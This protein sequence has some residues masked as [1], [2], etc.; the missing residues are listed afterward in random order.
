MANSHNNGQLCIARRL[1]GC[2]EP[3]RFGR[4]GPARYR[5]TTRRLERV[6]QCQRDIIRKVTTPARTVNGNP[7]G[8]PDA[9]L[10]HTELYDAFNDSQVALAET[11]GKLEFVRTEV[12]VTQRE[13]RTLRD[14]N[15]RLVARA[16]DLAFSH[17]ESTGSDTARAD[18]AAGK[19]RPEMERVGFRENMRVML[20]LDERAMRQK[21]RD[22]R[23]GGETEK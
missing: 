19:R 20:A 13:V 21:Q 12:D 23:C 7:T 6:Q 14:E 18:Q 8:E 1:G 17:N 11:R 2:V 5:G 4:V 10:E 16:R 15:T 22:E 9:A 3:D